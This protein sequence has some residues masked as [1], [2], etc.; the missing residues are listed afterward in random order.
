MT[1]DINLRLVEANLKTSVIGKSSNCPNEYHKLIDSTN[2]RL[3]ELSKNGANSGTIVLAYEQTS[4]RGRFGHSFISPPG[5]GLYLSILYK[6]SQ[7]RHLNLLTLGLGVAAANVIKFHTGFQIKLKWVNDLIANE[8][9]LGG[10]L[11]ESPFVVNQEKTLIIGIGINII[12]FVYDTDKILTP[13]EFLN[14]LTTKPINLELFIADLALEIETLL[15]YIESENFL[16]SE[17]VKQW[18]EYNCTIDKNIKAILGNDVI[19]GRAIGIN[20]SGELIIE[21]SDTDKP[22]T[23]SAGQVSIRNIDGKYV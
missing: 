1:I 12:P 14:N 11:V 19:F 21:T 15:F 16:A 22:I 4:G 20:G 2:N 9:K 18:L 23:L 5:H 8:K 17:I 3:I 7:D 6:T 13:I 10:I